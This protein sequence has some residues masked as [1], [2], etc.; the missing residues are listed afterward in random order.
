MTYLMQRIDS[1]LAWFVIA[2]LIILLISVLVWGFGLKRK[3]WE[4][5][6]LIARA[7]QA[8][9]TLERFVYPANLDTPTFLRESPHDGIDYDWRQ[10]IRDQQ[11]LMRKP[12]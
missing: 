9:P 5:E 6:R 12:N 7:K 11:D 2:V 4:N 3:Q 10:V 8:Q 1:D